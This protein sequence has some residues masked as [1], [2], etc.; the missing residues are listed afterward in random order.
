MPPS[1]SAIEVSVAVF[2]RASL[3]CARQRAM[4]IAGDVE[5]T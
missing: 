2:Y 5:E 1:G 3:V 4:C